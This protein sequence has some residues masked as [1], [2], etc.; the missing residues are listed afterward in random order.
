[1]EVVARVKAILRR[2]Y[3]FKLDEVRKS[4]EV[5]KVG[6]L[7]LDEETVSQEKPIKKRKP[8]TKKKIENIPEDKLNV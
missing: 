2:S 6:E 8:R 4:K 3:E 7:V 1:M 5:L